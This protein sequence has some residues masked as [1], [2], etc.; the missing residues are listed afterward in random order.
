[1]A[2][3]ANHKAVLMVEM[4]AMVVGGNPMPGATI[5]IQTSIVGVW[6]AAAA[7]AAAV[8]AAL[9]LADAQDGFT[10]SLLYVEQM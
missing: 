4:A 2:M 7:A 10:H 3:A 9:V 1:M 6:A 8:L 5:Q